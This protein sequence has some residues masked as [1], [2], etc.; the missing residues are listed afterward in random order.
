[1]LEA[2]FPRMQHLTRELSSTPSTINRVTE[3]WIPKMLEMDAN[4][5]SST[6]VQPAFKQARLPSRAHDFEIGSRYAPTFLRSRHLLA[7]NAMTLNRRQDASG[8]APQFPGDKRQID[9]VD[10]PKRELPRK[11][12]V[13]KII[14]RHHQTT[15]RFFIQPMNNPRSL[16]PADTRKI[17]AMRQQSVNQCAAFAA[18]TRVNRN[19]RAFVY[20]DQIVVFVQD[21]ERDL[22]RREIDRFYRR[23]DQSNAVACSNSVARTGNSS[24]YC[25]VTLANKRL[26][27]R[28]GKF[29]CCFNKKTIQPRAGIR[30][31]DVEFAA[32][33]LCH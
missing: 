14:L 11:V 17:F 32:V 12:D 20:Y 21:R 28:P 15:A 27:S 33:L 31:R 5:M 3:D 2:K 19:P 29:G 1:M 23:L 22:F 6:T 7:M 25:Y 9:L 18:G 24:V 16:L 26:N 10:R 30:W 8:R 4:L 13:R